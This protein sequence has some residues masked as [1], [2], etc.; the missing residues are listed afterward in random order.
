M[1]HPH[2]TATWLLAITLA[3]L[4]AN[5]SAQTVAENYS[6]VTQ[7]MLVDPPA[8]DWTMWRRSYGHWGHSPLSQILSLIHI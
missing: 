2:R 3:F 5:A 4:D 8:E 7:E 6:P 1:S